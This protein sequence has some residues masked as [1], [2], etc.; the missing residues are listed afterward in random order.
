MTITATTTGTTAGAR[1]HARA[2]AGRITDSMPVV[3]ASNWP[4]PPAD[5]DPAGLTWAETVP[6]GRYTSKVLARGT[7]LRLHDVAGSACAHLLL[8][9]ADAPWERLNV[10]DTVKVPWQAYLGP[11]HP[12]LSDQGRVLAT[13]VADGSGHHDALCGTT[14]L[15]AN[16]ARYGAGHVHSASPAG[17]EMFTLAA[18]KHGLTPTDVAP[19]VSF[20]HGVEVDDDGSLRSTGSAGAGTSVDLIMHLPCVVAIAN[21]AHPVDPSPTFDT[22]SLE[23]LAWTA[24]PDLDTLLAGVADTDPEYQRAVANS[25]DAWAAARF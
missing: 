15:A 16:T 17:R 18:A 7:R 25:E 20:F 13:I 4:N 21:T 22:T 3:P 24:R 5:V 19:S 14:T 9:R 6:G 12:L 1:E 2:Q 10:A 23:V 8:W 11:G